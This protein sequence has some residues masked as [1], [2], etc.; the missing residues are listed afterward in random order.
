MAIIIPTMAMVYIYL[1]N[2]IFHCDAIMNYKKTKIVMI[3]FLSILCFLTILM[4]VASASVTYQSGYPRVFIYNESPQSAWDVL[5]ATYGEAGANAVLEHV[6]PDTWLF[7]CQV[8]SETTGSSPLRVIDENIMFG[9]AISGYAFKGRMYTEN[10]TISGFSSTNYSTGHVLNNTETGRTIRLY[11]SGVAGYDGV[12]YGIRNTT[13][14]GITR[15]DIGSV[16]PEYH[17]QDSYWYN[18]TWDDCYYGIL[19]TTS[20]EN[21][22]FSNFTIQNC[23]PVYGYGFRSVKMHNSTLNNINIINSGVYTGR[24]SNDASGSY[25]LQISGNNNIA[26]NLYVNGTRYSGY[27]IGGSNW[28]ASNWSAIRTHHNAMELQMIDSTFDGILVQ[29]NTIHGIFSD[30][31][32]EDP[33][34][35]VNNNVYKNVT[36]YDTGSGYAIYQGRVSNTIFR[37][38]TLTGNALDVQYGTNLTFVNISHLSGTT[39]FVIDDYG[40]TPYND[41]DNVK[42]INSVF[43]GTNQ[44]LYSRNVSLVNSQYDALSGFTDAEYSVLYP[45]DIHVVNSTGYVISNAEVTVTGS[46]FSLNEFL[47]EVTMAHTDLIGMLN[48]SQQI[49]VGDFLRDSGA[50]YTYYSPI[51]T[52]SKDNGHDIN[53]EISPDS[54]WYSEDPNIPTY[55]ITAIIIDVATTGPQITGFAPSEDNP[56]TAGESKM[57][58]IWTD[59]DLIDMKWYVDGNLVSSGSMEYDWAILDGSHTIM[60]T[61]SNFNGAVLQTWEVTEG[62]EITADVPVEEEPPTTSG[63]GLSFTPTAPTFESEVGDSTNFVVSSEQT[64]TSSTWYLNNEEVASGTT[65]YTQNWNTAG[66]HAV[67]FD[68]VA[69]AGTISRTWTVTVPEPASS[70]TS[71]VSIAPSSTVVAPGDSFTLDVY[72]DPGQPLSGS[73]FNLQY[74]SIV[75]ASSVSDGGLFTAGDLSSTFNSGQIDN[76]DRVIRGVYSAIVGYGT[77]SDACTMATVDM[78]AGST[79]GVVNFTLSNVV[80]S[81][82]NSNPASYDVTYASVLVDTAPEFARIPSVTADETDSISFTIA[83]TDAEGDALTYS[84]T[85]LPGSATFDANTATFSWTPAEGDAGTYTASFAVTDGY[86]SDSV[87]ATITV[88]ELN[89]APVFTLFEPADGAE[90]EEGSTVSISVDASDS[91]DQS[92][93]YII[94]I[95]G[96]IVSTTKDYSWTTDY[97][98]AGTY[99][100]TAIVSDGIDEVSSTHSVTIT[101]LHPRWDVNEDGIVN[102]LDITLVGQNYGTTYTSEYP[103]WD[104]NQDGSVNIQDLSIVSGHFGE[105]VL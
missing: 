30:V 21:V 86:L 99:T 11:G 98:S 54:T 3:M 67:R 81:D 34:P 96:D 6:T 56:F 74:N 15:T 100:I 84:A 82:A 12:S 46:T 26:N 1:Y 92:L 61:G 75:S 18:V 72:I 31:G 79:S 70:A 16:S 39:G 45:L 20:I 64:F 8:L 80:L 95:N 66:T 42:I 59:E 24:S 55:T 65:T 14:K 57:F 49:Y 25:G 33:F 101:D 36:V 85:S 23:N 29:N 43:T 71:S 88:D 90:F 38:V 76:F 17:L 47:G 4:G 5:E 93:S 53:L 102:V 89:H 22:T 104:V 35:V 32:F 41:T 2:T 73:Q 50:G 87:S 60:F 10:A 37:D 83:A 105:T 69:A 7:K 9:G 77:V 52:A 19:G 40:N 103:R 94:K 91:D 68:G 13:F 58:R 78:I 48:E 62:I 28:T 51:L 44:I 63:T 27:N 97:T